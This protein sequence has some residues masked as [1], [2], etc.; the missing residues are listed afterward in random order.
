[1][2]MIFIFLLIAPAYAFDCIRY[3]SEYAEHHTVIAKEDREQYLPTLCATT[4][5]CHASPVLMSFQAYSDD[6]IHCYQSR[7]YNFDIRLLDHLHVNVTAYIHA[8]EQRWRHAMTYD[9][10]NLQAK[11][12]MTNIIDVV[13]IR[14]SYLREFQ[15][16]RP[17]LLSGDIALLLSNN[18]RTYSTD[19]A[20]LNENIQRMVNTTEA[21]IATASDW[22]HQLEAQYMALN[23][24][25]AE[26]M[27][28]EK[29]MKAVAVVIKK[30]VIES[31]LKVNMDVQ[32]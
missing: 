32:I 3:A 27:R 11:D 28:R 18:R 24:A 6:V 29:E 23:E 7:S 19:S 1:M 14:D 25:I 17:F 13:R 4:S 9:A 20:Y 15:Y 10:I 30:N 31:L 8:K 22:L 12:A 5:L 21:Q 2:N 16:S 26:L